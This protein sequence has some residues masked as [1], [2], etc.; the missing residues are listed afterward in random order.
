MVCEEAPE[1]KAEEETEP[2][3]EGAGLHNGGL[4]CRNYGT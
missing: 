1:E 4:V 3:G 2:G